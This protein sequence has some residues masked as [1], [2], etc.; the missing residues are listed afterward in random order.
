MNCLNQNLY[1]DLSAT[2]KGEYK[3]LNQMPASSH[4]V[5]T[6]GLEQK[7]SINSAGIVKSPINA[8]ND[9]SP[10]KL[11]GIND[12]ELIGSLHFDK[13]HQ[14]ALHTIGKKKQAVSINTLTNFRN[15]VT[16]YYEQT[17]KAGSG[18]PAESE[19]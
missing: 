1:T 18:D 13:R 6:F 12:E 3:I 14:Y 9:P 5:L 4:P 2:R 8:V 7:A 16:N 17:G 11:G 15:R 10:A 19:K